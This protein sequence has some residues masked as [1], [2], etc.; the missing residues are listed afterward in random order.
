MRSSEQSSLLAP[1]AARAETSQGRQ[2]P[3]KKHPYRSGFDRDRDRIIHSSAFRRL[4]GKTQ[5]FTPSRNDNFRTRLTHSIEVAQIGR[6]IAK[7]LRL[8]ESLTE[9]ICLAHD[10]GH[11]P[12]GHCGESALAE[13]MK[14]DGGFEHNKQ[15]M[16]VI[17]ILEKPYP[18]FR[19]LNLLYETRIG[20]S[21]HHSPYDKPEADNFKEKNAS[22]EGQIAN[23]ADRIAYNCHDLEDGLRSRIIS[24]DDLKKIEIYRRA[25]DK[26]SADKIGDAYVRNNRIVKTVMN[27]LIGNTIKESE[28]RIQDF[29]P[30]SLSDVMNTSRQLIDLDKSLDVELREL[31]SFLLNQMYLGKEI[32]SATA[33]VG[34]WLSNLFER[35]M[36]NPDL[37]PGYYR[38]FIDEFG[39][40]RAVCDYIA[41]MTDSYCLKI[42]EA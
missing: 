15:T 24:H 42:L 7:S 5:V 35:F 4:E 27:R 11:S 34:D 36:R 3:Q 26:I 32:S 20:L 19:G 37:M 30:S 13:I 21:R 31:E 23:V 22:L 2:Y 6:T 14:D 41:G 12:F 17:E 39:L 25:Y 33:K 40:A 10:L 8:N 28:L 1:Y 9:A 18:E 38:K 29:A 16:R